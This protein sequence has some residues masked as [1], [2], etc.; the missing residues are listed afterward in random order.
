MSVHS[1]ILD[2]LPFQFCAARM[3]SG[4]RPYSSVAPARKPLDSRSSSTSGST[5][6]AAMCTAV[7]P[8]GPV[9]EGSREVAAARAFSLEPP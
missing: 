9:S 7:V 6:C 3:C 4:V 8:C 5:C 2:T 1:V